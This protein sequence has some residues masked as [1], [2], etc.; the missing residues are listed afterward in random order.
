MRPSDSTS[1]GPI[2]RLIAWEVT[3]QCPLRCRHCRASATGEKSISELST[4]ECFKLLDNV[5]SFAKPIIILTGGEPMTRDDIY[6]IAAYGTQ[7]GLRM[8]M[9]PCGLYIPAET[10]KKIQASGI[11]RISLSIDG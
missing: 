7:L 5:A 2:P 10:V 3:R 8:V 6:D 11:R 1:A 9:A 4:A